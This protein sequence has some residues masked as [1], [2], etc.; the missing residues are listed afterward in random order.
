MFWIAVAVVGVIQLAMLAEA[1]WSL[2]D[3]RI[4]LDGGRAVFTDPSSLYTAQWQGGWLFTYPTFSAVVFGVLGVLTEPIASAVI[5]L[6]GVL[7]LSRVSYLISRGLLSGSTAA[8]AVPP[9]LRTPAVFG[10]A[11]VLLLLSALSDPVRGT[12]GFGQV[13][14]ILTWLVVE[15][16]LGFGAR[17]RGRGAGWIPGVLTGVAAGVKITPALLLIPRLL[18]GDWRAARNGALAWAGTVAVGAA[19]APRETFDY[20]TRWLWDSSRPGP[21]WYQWNQSLTGTVHRLWGHDTELPP[22]WV[23]VKWVFL[24]AALGA[25]LF[26]ATTLMRRGDRVGCLLVGSLTIHLVSPISWYH[27]LVLIPAL[28]LWLLS[29]AIRWSGL[30]GILLAGQAVLL[31]V[32][33]IPGLYQRVPHDGGGAELHHSF[34]ELLIGEAFPI[35]GLSVLVTLACAVLDPAGRTGASPGPAGG[36]DGDSG[37]GPPTGR[38][39]DSHAA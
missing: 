31:A 28:V 20:F 18:A 32:T 30:W 4:Y 35:L 7:A 23:L 34:A 33:V 38:V 15:D 13:N 3:I 24:A 26:A 9:D 22:V 37:G 16:L 12:F 10:A 39:A 1:D 27:H 14:L 5:I 6:G 19:V 29:A 25:G 8:R 2:F 21:L 17:R 36:R 11:T